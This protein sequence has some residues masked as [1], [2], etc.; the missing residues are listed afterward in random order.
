MPTKFRVKLTRYR[1]TTTSLL[2]REHSVKAWTLRSLIVA[3]FG[4]LFASLF[5]GQHGI[6]FAPTTTI[7]RAYE[8]L[9][10]FKL[11][12]LIALITPVITL[13]T[14]WFAHYGDERYG[15]RGIKHVVKKMGK[16]SYNLKTEVITGSMTK[17]SVL[18]AI[19]SIL[20]I[21]PRALICRTS[22]SV[23]F[24]LT[25]GSLTTIAPASG[26]SGLTM[27]ESSAYETESRP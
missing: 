26:G 5:L 7:R 17:Q 9:R 14:A 20:T 22:L 8:Q 10:G 4:L 15:G 21:F 23:C 18:A 6:G 12:E 24:A 11:A 25:L 19:A 27:L 3:G 13:L 2:L 1:E 16:G